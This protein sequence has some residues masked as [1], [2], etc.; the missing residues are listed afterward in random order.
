VTASCAPYS[1]FVVLLQLP[2]GRA[3]FICFA[4]REFYVRLAINYSFTFMS[5]ICLNRLC[6]Q[7][8]SRLLAGMLS[9][10]LQHSPLKPAA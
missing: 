1:S 4:Q 9:E 10:L 2:Y 3:A 5:Y 8:I 7:N 6:A